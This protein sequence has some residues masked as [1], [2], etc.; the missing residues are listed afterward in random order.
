M[1]GTF[2]IYVT[3]HFS[4]AHS[5]RD[6]PG[7]C[8][9]IHGHNWTVEVFVKCE[10][11]DE[12]GIGIDFE[13]IKKAAKD[14]IQGLDHTHLNDLPAFKLVNPSSE[15]IAKYLYYEL[16]RK[17]NSDSVRVSRVKASETPGTGA[18]YWEE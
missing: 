3:T 12:I 15:N 18:A 6:Y 2:E 4:A 11:L 14:V 5:L 7:N 9:Q 17:L 10:E 1:A 8:A 13:N 16:R